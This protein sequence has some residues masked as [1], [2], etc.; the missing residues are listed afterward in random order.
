MR[1]FLHEGSWK[2]MN[3]SPLIYRLNNTIVLDTTTLGGYKIMMS[4]RKISLNL[5]WLPLLLHTISF[6]DVYGHGSL[7]LPVF[8]L[9]ELSLTI[10][11]SLFCHPFTQ[12]QPNSFL[13]YASLA[14]NIPSEG[15]ILRD[16]FPHYASQNITAVIFYLD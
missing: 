10:S 14:L 7:Q 15:S 13:P 16:F 5:R 8:L 6:K 3:S 11:L 12:R 4:S 9:L 1:S 2:S